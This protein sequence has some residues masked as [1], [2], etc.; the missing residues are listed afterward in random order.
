MALFAPNE[1][2]APMV[3]SRRQITALICRYVTAMEARGIPVE[4]VILFGSHA[5]GWSHAW[6]DIDIAV[7]SPKFASMSLLERY[8][9]LGLAN[10]ELRAPLDVVG[11]APSH[12]AHYEPGSFLEEILRTGVDV[13]VCSPSA[14]RKRRQGA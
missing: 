11:F 8:E 5:V 7:I 12:V 6:S 9:Q 4:P 2:I 1:G 3:T 14:M 13:T 10:R